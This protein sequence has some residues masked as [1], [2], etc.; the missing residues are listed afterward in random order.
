MVSEDSIVELLL[1][2]FRHIGNVHYIYTCFNSRNKYPPVWIFTDEVIIDGDYWL[3]FIKAEIDL[4]KKV[5]Y[6]NLRYVPMKFYREPKSIIYFGAK[7][8]YEKG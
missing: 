2:L 3:P 6:I 1:S 7:M 8:I 5:G 4:F